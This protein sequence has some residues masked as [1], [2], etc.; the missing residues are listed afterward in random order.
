VHLREPGE[1]SGTVLGYG[2]DDHGFESWQGLGI[3]LFTTVFDWLWGP[4]SLLYN[5]Y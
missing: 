3:F 1:L 4:Y 2:L 5:G